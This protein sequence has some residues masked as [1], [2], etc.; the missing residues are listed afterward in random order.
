MPN[1]PESQDEISSGRG[2]PKSAGGFTPGPV[3]RL[4]FALV[5]MTAVAF[6]GAHCSLLARIL[7]GRSCIDRPQDEI[8]ARNSCEISAV[9]GLREGTFANSRSCLPRHSGVFRAT[10]RYC[11]HRVPERAD[12]AH[13]F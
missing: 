10:S 8:L 9:T 7:R 13:Y 12:G 2:A 11:R 5:C 6:G 4:T 1:E 3:A